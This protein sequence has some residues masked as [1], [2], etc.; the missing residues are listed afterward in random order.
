[1]HISKQEPMAVDERRL[2]LLAAMLLPLRAC[3][4]T[5]DGSKPTMLTHHIVLESIKWKRKDAEAV[6]AL[7][8][9]AAELLHVS[10]LLQARSSPPEC[11]IFLP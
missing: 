8:A 3:E 2:A 6:S 5:R 10:Q 1:M 9:A 11:E 7:H 4:I